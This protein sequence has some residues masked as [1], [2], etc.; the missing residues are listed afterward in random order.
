MSQERAR[1][2][3]REYREGDEKAA[4]EVLNQYAA[5]FLGAAP[6][7]PELW[8]EQH[9]VEWRPPTLS[10][11]PDCFRLAEREGVVVGYAVVRLP[12][13]NGSQ[14]AVV[15]E[16]CVREGEDKEEVAG[17]LLADAEEMARSRGASAV[18]LQLCHEDGLVRRL[19]QVRNYD[20]LG[21]GTGV[22][23]A[24]VSD[25]AGL[26][27][28]MREELSARLSAS[29]FGRWQGVLDIRCGEQSARLELVEGRVRVVE[30]EAAEPSFS[31]DVSAEAL[32]LLLFGRISVGQVFLQDA[33]TVRGGDREVALEVLDVLFPQLPMYLP[34]SQSW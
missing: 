19:T 30:A 2:V 32:P 25:L 1:V 18:L 9:E 26:L 29:K 3:V 17:V 24:T 20:W 10:R 28:E 16:L 23:M 11:R 31:V 15:Q 34:V 27:D 12:E 13:G 8:R 21:P 6:V 22:F 5:G 14:S 7:T 4:A 33:M